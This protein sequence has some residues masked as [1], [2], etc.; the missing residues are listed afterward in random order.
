MKTLLLT[1]LS[2]FLL[3]PLV[4]DEDADSPV[5]ELFKPAEKVVEELKVEKNKQAKTRKSKTRK[6]QDGK[7]KNSNRNKEKDKKR[8]QHDFEKAMRKYLEDLKK[9]DPDTF[10]RMQALQESD[11]RQYKREI[12]VKVK[13]ILAARDKARREQSARIRDMKKSAFREKDPELKSQLMAKLR[14]ELGA[15]FDQRILQE[16]KQVV[17]M[18]KRLIELRQKLED[19]KAGREEFL[20]KQMGNNKKDSKSKEVKEKPVTPESVEEGIPVSK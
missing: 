10:V 16:E 17:A 4:A 15:M 13:A 5:K 14:T 2:S 7:S 6:V 18:E 9:N 8:N 11:P 3:L 12:R 20:D 19:K 1:F